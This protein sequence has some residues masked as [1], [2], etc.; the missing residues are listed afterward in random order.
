MHKPKGFYVPVD[1]LNLQEGTIERGYAVAWSGFVTVIKTDSTME[2]E[3]DRDF[4]FNSYEEVQVSI[5]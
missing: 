4:I 5:N 1:N 3:K 2:V